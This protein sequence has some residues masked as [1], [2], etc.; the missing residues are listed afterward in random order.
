MF[1][2]AIEVVAVSIAV[3]LVA[4]WV[5]LI[6]QYSKRKYAF[7]MQLLNTGLLTIVLSLLL[8]AGLYPSW[9]VIVLLILLIFWLSVRWTNSIC[10]RRGDWPEEK[11]EE[12]S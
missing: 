1:A 11:T 10:R 4:G 3:S 8:L 9:I 5:H 12:P 2:F 6:P 7:L